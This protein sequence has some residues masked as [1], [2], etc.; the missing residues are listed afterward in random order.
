[1]LHTCLLNLEGSR[2]NCGVNTFTW[3]AGESGGLELGSYKMTLLGFT[4]ARLVFLDPGLHI[5]VCVYI[6]S[7]AHV[8]SH[9]CAHECEGRAGG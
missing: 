9:V 4:H 6:C 2:Q 3:D 5:Y 8:N 7:H 1:M